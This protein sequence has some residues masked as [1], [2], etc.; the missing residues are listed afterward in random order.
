MD[1]N[2]AQKVNNR[3]ECLD[4]SGN[5]SENTCN[6]IGIWNEKWM[7]YLFFYHLSILKNLT[8]KAG[9]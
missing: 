9:D 2:S 7:Q 6:Q 5:K 3:R 1:A 8:M 4:K